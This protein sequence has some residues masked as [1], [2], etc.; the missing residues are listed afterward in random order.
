MRSLRSSR[1]VRVE[2]IQQL[3][4]AI[5]DHKGRRRESPGRRHLTRFVV[6]LGIRGSTPR[7][8]VLIGNHRGPLG[9]R[10]VIVPIS[11][12]TTGRGASGRRRWR[13][14]CVCRGLSP[15]DVRLDPRRVRTARL[16][17][18]LAERSPPTARC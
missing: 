4:A 2:R 12:T 17:A 18:T 13:T 7:A 14:S 16:G 5:I 8:I 1:N 6:P 15:H 10:A 3:E 9:P 11:L